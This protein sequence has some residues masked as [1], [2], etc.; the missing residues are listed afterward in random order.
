MSDHLPKL[1][2]F[3]GAGL[4]AE[5]G[6]QTFRDGNGLWA[7]YDPQEVCNYLNWI[8]NFELV[9][10]FYDLRREELGKVSP[11]AMHRYLA[12]LEQKFAGK[13]QIIH[14]TQNVDDLLER[15]G[16]HHIYHLHGELTKM[17]CP[18]CQKIWDIGYH[19]WDRKACECGNEKVK[20]KIVFFFEQAPLYKTMYEI[21]ENLQKYD[22][23]LVI[24]TSGNV[25]DISGMIQAI[26][27]FRGVEIGLK[28]LNNLESSSSI[29]ETIFDKTIFAPASK[30][31]KEI[32]KLLCAFYS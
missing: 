14:L 22:A 18:K 26:E 12:E 11:N 28:I 1:I 21:F 25:V 15:A 7:Q 10:H 23:L 9:H 6:L 16:A 29:D 32:D 13:V 2:V 17:I 30:A 27:T 4:S 24:G 8:E 20:P 5:S 31:V 19:Q 3:S